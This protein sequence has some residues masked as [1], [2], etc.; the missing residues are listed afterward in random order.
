MTSTSTFTLSRGRWS[1]HAEGLYEAERDDSSAII[2]GTWETPCAVAL[3]CRKDDWPL[4]KRR[5]HADGAWCGFREDQVLWREMQI[6]LA[7]GK[8]VVALGLENGGILWVREADDVTIY[9]LYRT[10]EDDGLIVHGELDIS[11]FSL[12]GQML[13]LA[14]ANNIFSESVLMDGDVMTIGTDDG[15]VYSIQLD[16]GAISPVG[17]I[18]QIHGG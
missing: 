3:A 9:S 2:L 13:W 7:V 14:T 18:G 17:R 16:T 5:F 8:Y 12:D 4:W 15:V 11:R 6:F 10:P 1:L